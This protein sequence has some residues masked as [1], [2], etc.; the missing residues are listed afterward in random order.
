[1]K[2]SHDKNHPGTKLLLYF[3]LGIIQS[4]L[5]TQPQLRRSEIDLTAIAQMLADFR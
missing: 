1:M 2:K 3:L 5:I 4:A